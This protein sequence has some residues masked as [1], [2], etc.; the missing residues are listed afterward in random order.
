MT[1][2]KERTE[3]LFQLYEMGLSAVDADRIRRIAMTLSRWDEAECN[4]DIQRDETTNKPVRCY[5]TKY[6]GKWTRRSYPIPDR[7][8]GAIRRLNAIC[9]EYGL[10]FYHQTDPR[11]ASL[12][13]SKE[14]I[15]GNNYTQNSTAVF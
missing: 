10:F 7:E 13:L 5:E 2:K 8:S 11:G 4:G 6:D 15:N 3:V 1:T 9:K 12:Y 14:E